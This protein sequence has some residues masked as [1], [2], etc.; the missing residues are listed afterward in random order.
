MYLVDNRL[1]SPSAYEMDPQQ[2][3]EAMLDMEDREMEL[4]AIFHSHPQGP[5]RPSTADLDVAFYPEAAYV[6]VSLR[7]PDKPST[8]GF[9]IK[10]RE[11]EEIPI[12]VD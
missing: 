10:G 6:I 1:A 4:Q 9:I 8:R 7:N 3:L 5:D 12:I 11:V 2:Q